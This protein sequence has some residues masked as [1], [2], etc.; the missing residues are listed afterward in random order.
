MANIYKFIDGPTVVRSSKMFGDHTEQLEQ[1]AG[2]LWCDDVILVR[3]SKVGKK[4]YKSLRR[5]A[6]KHLKKDDACYVSEDF[7]AFTLHEDWESCRMFI[8]CTDVEGGDKVLLLPESDWSVPKKIAKRA[9]LYN[10]R[11]N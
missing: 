8:E 9:E 1:A 11:I 2:R 3:R 7:D 6:L 5:S 10:F 4:A